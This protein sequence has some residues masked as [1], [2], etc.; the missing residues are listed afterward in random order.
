MRL[1]ERIPG[2]ASSAP[3]SRCRIGS[4]YRP[5]LGCPK[6]TFLTPTFATEGEHDLRFS[7]EIPHVLQGKPLLVAPT[8]RSR[9]GK[10]VV[11][12]PPR[13]LDAA[14]PVVS[15]T[16]PDAAPKSTRGLRVDVQAYELLPARTRVE[17]EPVRVPR[18]AELSLGLGVSALASDVG[19]TQFLLTALWEGGRR[20]LLRETV[21]STER[22]RWRDHR[23]DLGEFSEQMVRFVFRTSPVPDPG[24]QK[25]SA[26]FPVWGAPEIQTQRP[27]EG[28]RNL[29]LI[30]LDTL[31][32]DH[33]GRRLHDTPL[34]PWM[35]RLGVE[36]TTFQSVLSTYPSTSASHMS[37]FTGVYPVT[38]GVRFAAHRLAAAQSTLPE[39]LA[40]AGYATAAVTENAML[41]GS[42]GFYRG[43]DVYREHRDTLKQRGGG[44]DRT[45][46]DGISWLARHRND[47]F[48][49]FLHTYEVHVPHRDVADALPDLPEPDREALSASEYRWE[50]LR[51]SYA[52]GVRYADGAVERLFGE[53]A[54][55][56]LLDDTLVVITADHGEELGEHGRFGH[57]QTVYDEVLRIPLLL[58]RPGLVPAAR[59]VE[60]VVSLVDVT[61]T[62]LDLLGLDEAADVEGRSLVPRL[63]GEPIEDDGV[64]FAELQT[65]DTQVVA[66][67]SADT[68]WI[69]TP[70]AIEVFDVEAD[71]GET[72]PLD[73]PA[74][75][76][77]GEELIA[78]YLRKAVPS[79]ERSDQ[80]L[81]GDT[82]RKLEALGYV[83]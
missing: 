43:F 74:R 77:R 68:K 2:L 25:R 28:R 16:L 10:S 80:A 15:W 71:P 83:D 31:R 12:Y 27:R 35:D 18:G 81:D 19:A 58:W 57:S 70:G 23:I 22:G 72:K 53:L 26:A 6:T 20:E 29:I 78:A 59:S 69:G 48:F 34:T 11:A 45:F 61:P 51:R 21:S 32:A 3:V 42:S 82:I 36:G 7:A 50:K 8:V 24:S 13:T 1:T 56:D 39:L 54:R 38:H 62:L 4:E 47:L 5:G 67:R 66:A 75:R 46:G 55:L 63:V 60:D 44:I 73:D 52:A 17:T 14:P 64:R 30:S 41:L 79:P 9:G 76:R 37:L 65:G 40:R 33:V 49:L